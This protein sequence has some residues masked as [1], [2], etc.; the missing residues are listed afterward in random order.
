MLNS[1]A[2]LRLFMFIEM[3]THTTVMYFSLIPKVCIRQS[4]EY[5]EGPGIKTRSFWDRL[6]PVTVSA[7]NV[8]N[9]D[10]AECGVLVAG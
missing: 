5:K 8:N 3:R 2:H 4:V 6:V 9:S 7:K 10:L 1:G